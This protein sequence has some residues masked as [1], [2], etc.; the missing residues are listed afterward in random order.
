VVAVKGGNIVDT[1]TMLAL[2]AALRDT[3]IQIAEGLHLVAL[4]EDEYD[5]VML[6]INHSCEPN[7]GLAGNIVMVAMRDVVPGEELT[8]D[9]AMFD[10]FRAPMHCLCGTA[11]CR[12]TVTGG[13]WRDPSLQRRYEGWFATYIANRQ[14]ADPP[15]ST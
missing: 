7:V 9:Y 11:S 3:D 10:T 8:I 4:S 6:Y 2:P 14:G 13:D 5:S 12:G 1:A 15:V